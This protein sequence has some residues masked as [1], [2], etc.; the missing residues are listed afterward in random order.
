MFSVHASYSHGYVFTSIDCSLT[1]CRIRFISRL[2]WHHMGWWS[3]EGRVSSIWQPRE[4]IASILDAL[5]VAVSNIGD[6]Y[7]QIEAETLANPGAKSYD[8]NDA[9][10]YLVQLIAKKGSEL[11]VWAGEFQLTVTDKV[12]DELAEGYKKKTGIY[13]K[14]EMHYTRI[15]EFRWNRWYQSRV[16]RSRWAGEAADRAEMSSLLDLG[17]VFLFCWCDEE[18]ECTMTT[19]ADDRIHKWTHN[20]CRQVAQL[21][22]K[23]SKA[24]SRLGE[25]AVS[26]L[27]RIQQ[28]SFTHRLG[29]CIQGRR[30][31]SSQAHIVTF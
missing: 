12:I 14:R 19:R 3:F 23:G 11:K 22:L 10:G 9:I 15:E 30:H 4:A 25:L 6:H 29:Q 24:F 2:L 31:H 8:M 1:N 20:L 28:D 27:L 18:V 26:R 17:R 7:N 21:S 13:L 16:P 5:V